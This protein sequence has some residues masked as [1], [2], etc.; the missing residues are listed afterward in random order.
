M[1]RSVKWLAVALI[2]GGV[3]GA[4]GV[5]IYQNPSLKQNVDVYEAGNSP[6]W[7]ITGL[8]YMPHASVELKGAV[9]KSSYGASCFTL[10]VDN[11]LVSGTGN[12]LAHGQC[13]QAGL[14]QPTN[15]VPTRGK[16]V[17]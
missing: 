11:L 9:N 1:T 16:L 14:T 8:V 4:G 3:G 5:A 10:V 6:A 7:D 15:P 12:I 13:G 17:S 2:I